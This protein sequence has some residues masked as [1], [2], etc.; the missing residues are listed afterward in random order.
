MNYILEINDATKKFGGLM[1]NEG[2]TF[3]VKPGEVVGVV[4]P[5][6]AGKTTLFNSVSCVHQLTRG[7]IIFNGQDISKM[8]NNQACKL[9]IG[10]TFQIPQTITTLTVEENVLIGSLCH[11][12]NMRIARKKAEETVKFCGLE[13]LAKKPASV[14]NVA[15][16]KRLE[17]ARAYATEPKLLLL[18]E[19]M[20]GLT[21]TER[22]ESVE[23]IRAINATGVS[24]LT[25][26]HNMD[27]VMKVSN[28]V[29]VLNYGK[30]LAIGTPE[31][32]TSNAEVIEAYLGGGKK[33]A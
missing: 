23:L 10:R 27:V 21:A 20:A 29:V 19:T 30:V 11:T 18:D 9:G 25:I 26:E 4:G 33:D 15:Q 31:E 16:K 2:I 14:L 13:H 17:I 22:A 3:N 28:R 5:N 12:N 1:A 6:G 7:S 24:I 8:T 32:I